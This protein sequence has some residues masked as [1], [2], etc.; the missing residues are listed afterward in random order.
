VNQ[1]TIAARYTLTLE[2]IADRTQR[3]LVR[4]YGSLDTYD[5]LDADR[6]HDLGQPIV[7]A[8]A[9]AA[10]NTTGTYLYAATGT[11]PAAPSPLIVADAASRLYDPFDRLARNLASGM[12]YTDAVAGGLSQA[13][14]L[15]DD[16]VF[17]TARASMS[18]MTDLTDWQR[19]LS[20]KC[21]QWCMKLAGVVF[22]NAGQATFGHPHCRCVPVPVAA[23]GDHNDRIRDDAGFD[24]QAEN[25]YDQRAARKRLADST[26]IAQRNSQQAA[27]EALTEPDPRRRDRLETRAQEWETRAEATAER[28]RILETGTHRLAA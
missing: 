8:A 25:L 11:P 17:R 15:G 13:D 27:T 5:E 4:L 28:L 14:A 21:C 9:T 2:R 3:A 20:S 16:A 10:Q 12:P 7:R 1:A 19:R 24:A 18:Q 26:R 23:V 6:F 22:D